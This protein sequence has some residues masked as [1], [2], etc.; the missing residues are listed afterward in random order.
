MELAIAYNNQRSKYRSPQHGR[1]TPTIISL[2]I[3][4]TLWESSQSSRRQGEST[5]PVSATLISPIRRW[6]PTTGLPPTEPRIPRYFEIGA[7]L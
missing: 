7:K 5:C 3:T 2:S 4:T 1:Q 6:I